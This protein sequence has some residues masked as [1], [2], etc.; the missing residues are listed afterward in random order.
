MISVS[1][2][3]SLGDITAGRTIL[4]AQLS[5]PAT[6]IAACITD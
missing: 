4:L 2:E 6:A 1:R 5:T 3:P